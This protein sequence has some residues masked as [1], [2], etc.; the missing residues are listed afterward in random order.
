MIIG[1]TLTEHDGMRLTPNEY[2]AEVY[3]D[4][5]GDFDYVDGVLERHDWGDYA[6]SE[7]HGEVMA[8]IHDHKLQ[9]KLQVIPS[10]TLQISPTRFRVPDVS[11]FSRKPANEER[12]I[13][14]APLVVIE[15]LSPEDSFMYLR[16]LEADYR[17]MGIPNIW[18]LDPRQMTGWYCTPDAW[19]KTTTFAIPDRSITL[20]L[21]T[22][23]TVDA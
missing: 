15:I 9:S 23:A 5:E 6:H 2:F 10:L 14:T 19:I 21:T 12:A 1:Q 4:W 18:F 13:A 3:R 11:I 16:S 8:W 17:R 20:D 7:L 22:I